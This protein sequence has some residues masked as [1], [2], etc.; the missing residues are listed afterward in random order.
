VFRL[1]GDGVTR[2]LAQIAAEEIELAVLHKVE[3]QFGYQR[4]ALP[5]VVADLL[6]FDRLPPGGAEIV[7][8]AVDRLVE[9]KILTV[10]GPY[11]YV[12]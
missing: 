11:V 3:D 4:D 12:T 1:P 7:G 5:R 6:G 9:R 2:S 10:S 8:T